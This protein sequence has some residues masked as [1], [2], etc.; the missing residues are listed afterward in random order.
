MV[1]LKLAPDAGSRERAFA[2]DMRRFLEIFDVRRS[3]SLTHYRLLLSRGTFT[4]ILVFVRL[5]ILELGAR[6]EQADGQTE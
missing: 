4:P 5:F 1:C 2:R 3:W 6:K